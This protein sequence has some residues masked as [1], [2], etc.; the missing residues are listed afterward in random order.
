MSVIH[1]DLCS[2]CN[3]APTC[4]N[5]G[6]PE[7]PVFFCEEFDAYVRVE[8]Q[9]IRAPAPAANRTVQIDRRKGLC[10]NCEHW[11]ACTMPKP[12]GGVWHCEEYR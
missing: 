10:S 4:T 11:S 12:E 6:S 8:A 5:R 2:T 1:R 7:A 9:G 3:H